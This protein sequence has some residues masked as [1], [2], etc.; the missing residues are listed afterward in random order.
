[1][2]SA[3]FDSDCGAMITVY[4]TN[5]TG[6]HKVIVSWHKEEQNAELRQSI[7]KIIQSIDSQSESGGTPFLEGLLGGSYNVN[8]SADYFQEIPNKTQERIKQAR[9]RNFYNNIHL[10]V[11]AV[12]E[13]ARIREQE[14][15][16]QAWRMSRR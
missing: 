6:G 2:A 10:F 16:N 15:A 13:L 14:A 8:T 4:P 9:K 12:G 1:M 7:Y 11:Q 5:S 3:A